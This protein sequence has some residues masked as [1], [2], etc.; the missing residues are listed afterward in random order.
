MIWTPSKKIITSRHRQRGNL[1]LTILPGQDPFFSETTLLL[2]GDE[3]AVDEQVIT[4]TKGGTWTWTIALGPGSTYGEVSNDQ[5]K[6]GASS[7]RARGLTVANFWGWEGP[8]IQS[9]TDFDIGAGAFTVELHVYPVEDVNTTYLFAAWDATQGKKAWYLNFDADRR[10]NFAYSTDGSSQAFPIAQ[11]GPVDGVPLNQ[12]SH[13]ACTR[14]DAGLMSIWQEG[15]LV[16]SVAGV[17]ATF[18]KP[19]AL[20]NLNI[21]SEARNNDPNM[22]QSETYAANFRITKGVARYT[23]PFTPPDARYPNF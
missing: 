10:Y 17:T 5:T 11:M 12:W 21:L 23:A 1:V 8:N 18:G 3:T 2:Y 9:I 14:N 22:G 19:A 20:L 16:G 4:A 6:F 13:I 7:L 15:A